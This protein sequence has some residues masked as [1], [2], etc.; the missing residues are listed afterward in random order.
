MKRGVSSY[1]G[2]LISVLVFLFLGAS[3][4]PGK[5]AGPVARISMP[6]NNALVRANVPVFGVANAPKFKLYRL[7]FGRGRK[8]EKWHVIKVSTRPARQDPWAAGKVKW[9]PNKGA[10][11]NLATWDT[12]LTSYQYG[13]QEK[14]LNG[15]Y[16]LRLVV[17]NKTGKTAEARVVVTVA[18][19]ITRLTGGV[20]ESRDGKA[21]LNVPKGGVSSALLLAS[22]QATDP[23]QNPPSIDL[24]APT[25]LIRVGEVYEFRPP[26]LNFTKPASF[27]MYYKKEDLERADA[28]GKRRKLPASKLGIYAYRPVEEV[29][30]PVE[31]FQ[32]HPES[33]EVRASLEEATRYV[34][35]YAL[36]AD[37]TP[38]EPPTLKAQATSTEYRSIDVSGKAEPFTTVEILVGDTVHGKGR[39]DLDGGF[40]VSGLTLDVGTNRLTAR[41]VDAAGNKGKA[42]AATE[43]VRERH[44]PKAVRKIE[45]LGKL[46]AE[47]GDRL[48]AKLTGEDSHPGTNTCYVRVSSSTD[49][50]GMELELVETG[51]R[52][53]LYVA[54][55][56]VG[57][58]T[59]T[60]EATI[61]ALKDGEKIT[62][63]S[64]RNKQ[65]QARIQYVDRAP[66]LAPTI[67]S[68]THP[69]L[70]QNT[71]ENTGSP[72]DQWANI[73]GKEGAALSL[74]RDGT[75]TYL[76]LTKQK[77][78][79]HLG[80]TARSAGYSTS[81]FPL[82]AFDYLINPD[83]K[84]DVRIHKFYRYL[85]ELN[86]HGP[87]NR[88][89]HVSA[90]RVRL[91]G[92]FP[93]VVADGKW[94][95]TEL[96]VGQLL[97]RFQQSGKPP[98]VD[99]IEFI[100][101]DQTAY[102]KVVY[103]KTG[104][105]GSYYCI[106]NFRILGYG[107]RKVA[108]TW[109]SRDENGITGYSYLLDR[110]ADTVPPEE[111]KGAGTSR[112]YDG[113]AD[114]RWYFHV[115]A[116]DNSGN[117]GPANH[118]MIVVDAEPPTAEFLVGEGEP[119]KRRWER[120]VRLKIDDGQGSGI[121]PYSVHLKVGGLSYTT[122]SSALAYDANT[123]LL[124]FDP[125]KVEPHPRL[126]ADGEKVELRLLAAADHAGHP[127]RDLPSLSR[128]A[129]S[130]LQVTPPNP[131]G[132]NGWYVSRPQIKMRAPEEAHVGYEWM[133]APD[134]DELFRKGNSINVL[135]VTVKGTDGKERCYR[136][137]FRLDTTVP[138]VRARKKG[139]GKKQRII[140]EHQDYVLARGGLRC[141][142]YKA[143]DLE[144]T[145]LWD[146]EAAGFQLSALRKN[147][148]RKARSICWE[149]YVRPTAGDIYTVRLAT[150][151]GQR[152]RLLVSGE[153]IL[154]TRN[155]ERADKAVAREIALKRL[156]HPVE[157]RWQSE[158]AVD[159]P[160]VNLSWR[161][162]KRAAGKAPPTAFFAPR[163]L[164]RILYRWDEGKEQEYQRPLSVPAG[165]HVLHYHAV[166]EAGHRSE[167][168]SITTEGAGG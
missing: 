5:E 150:A 39:A 101:W 160:V 92:R 49:P 154:D 136:K 43:V 115:R 119:S 146:R 94:H 28:E 26:G 111:Q 71:F 50:D 7:E 148:R 166:D 64:L 159:A 17:E 167:E 77:H 87:G 86:D 68:S 149:G 107:G 40:S 2:R 73:G 79:G 18:R 35:F 1:P 14:N 117:W 140:L 62:V 57:R 4:A 89:F 109:S 93:N 66:P 53:G 69:S 106:D 65:M 122:R 108:F 12:G 74:E 30:A 116:K 27:R 85:I 97:A 19:A 51:P 130:P 141:R 60:A 103:G 157:V 34:A 15:L 145:M 158:E 134:E 90:T 70:C 25:G 99:A 112:E 96:D 110:K 152:V 55:F 58:E 163:S 168:S 32:V 11:G 80:A 36:M 76:K 44:P 124:T 45:I 125:Q 83:V 127:V 161:R 156:M 139:K 38:P 121:N 48:L 56:S 52:T 142:G 155:A 151:K 29:W 37:V 120:P 118:Y 133:I 63:V 98:D 91:A 95:H 10:N 129:A 105:K 88:R 6:W 144:T 24:K 100:N 8:P 82:I 3:S 42:S 128:V 16:T 59:D 113:L 54:T 138:S 75:N 20:I 13:V 114:G 153:V 135:T 72:L 61:G 162:G 104:S 147:M 67:A 164:A 81:R 102:M 23:V 165:K 46:K 31:G 84:M 137:E 21:F 41:A 47:R 126:P 9:D 33:N 78:R 123:G 131:D 143:R 22:L 132:K